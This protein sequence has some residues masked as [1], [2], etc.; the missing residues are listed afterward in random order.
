MGPM[1]GSRRGRRTLA[2]TGRAALFT[3]VL[4][5]GG[6]TT[7]PPS[8]PP[9]ETE[10]PVALRVTTVTGAGSMDADTRADLESAVGDVLSSY[11]VQGFLGDY[12][13]D[14]FVR[15]FDSFTS[16][17]ARDA[18][19]DIDWLTAARLEDPK[20]VRATRL[21]ARLSFLVAGDDVVGGTATVRFAFEATLDGEVRPVRLRGRLML[22][23]DEGTWSVF[24]Y[25]VTTNA[26]GAVEGEVSS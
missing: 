26:P 8:D 22:V 5:L 24:G 11:V 16:G 17:A 10:E 7:E 13:R 25:D 19:R 21:D 12:P 9:S 2:A 14:D 3:A 15:A 1:A 18:A 23:E 6:C 4:A 20:A